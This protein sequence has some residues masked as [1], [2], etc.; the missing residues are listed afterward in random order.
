MFYTDDGRAN[1]P[2]LDGVIWG[3]KTPINITESLT[4][5][6]PGI[7]AAVLKVPYGKPDY[8]YW[9]PELVH[10]RQTYHMF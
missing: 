3:H 4:E 1:V 8:I 5:A 7:I 10:A 9:A 6:L 2:G